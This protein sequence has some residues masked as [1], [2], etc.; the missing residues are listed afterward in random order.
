[1]SICEA[2]GMRLQELLVAE[3][4]LRKPPDRRGKGL[5]LLKIGEQFTFDWQPWDKS[6]IRTVYR[7]KAQIARLKKKGWHF[8]WDV[9][10]EGHVITRL[11]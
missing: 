9:L 6:S 11:A 10:P 4:K 7:I 8:K 5:S 2:R 3:L 1:M